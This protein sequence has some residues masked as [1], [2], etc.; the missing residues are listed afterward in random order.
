MPRGLRN[1]KKRP[2]VDLFAKGDLAGLTNLHN[3][4]HVTS[5]FRE[6]FF[7]RELLFLKTGF[8]SRHLP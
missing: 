3:Q 5:P 7:M 1:G 4:E 2:G 8:F 6:S